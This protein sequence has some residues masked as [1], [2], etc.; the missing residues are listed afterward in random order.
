MLTRRRSGFTLIELLV[1]VSIIALLVAIL[2]PALSKARDQAK[3]VVC[4][5]NLRTIH[6][7]LQLYAQDH[8]DRYPQHGYELNA[9]L[10]TFNQYSWSAWRRGSLYD[11]VV[12]GYTDDMEVF[13][14]PDSGG[15]GGVEISWPSDSS[16]YPWDRFWGNY[17]YFGSTPSLKLRIVGNAGHCSGNG[18]TTASPP[19]A[20]LAADFFQMYHDY[21]PYPYNHKGVGGNTLF[22][23]GYVDW[24]NYDEQAYGYFYHPV[25][26]AP[27]NYS[28]THRF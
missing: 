1:V 25:W 27:Y 5:T 22:S 10:Y 24:Y 14:C 21:E 20:V 7:M 18:H 19:D 26:S 8:Q 13:F 9:Y 28:R 4:S 11:L 3:R 17:S 15:N 12:G 23:G 6:M 16:A 2:L